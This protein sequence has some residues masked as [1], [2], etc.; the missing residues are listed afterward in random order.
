MKLIIQIPCFNEAEQLPQTLA[1]LPREVEGFDV[2]EW[3]VIDDGST[4]DTVA[5]ARAH[6]VDHLVRL[7]NN[8]GLATGFQAGID[9][10]LKLGADV[11]VN[12]DADNQYYGPDVARLVRPILEARAD[13]VIGDREVTDIK[14]FSRSKKLLQRLGSWV[15]RQ[16]SSTSV[17]DTTSGFRAYNREAAIQML[18]VSKFTYTLET[19]IQA[20]KL[21]VAVDH[22]SVRTNAKTRESRLFP[23]TGAYV[24]RNAVSIFRVYAQYEPLT[25]FWSLAAV[26]GVVSIGV[27]IRFVVAYVDGNG[28]GHVQSLILGAVL[29]IA[30]VVLWALGVIGD[31]L[32]AQRVMVQR[33]FE[34]VRRIELELEVPP[35]HYEPGG[36]E[37]RPGAPR[38]ALAAGA[39]GAE[40]AGPDGV[41][42]SAPGG[43]EAEKPGGET[44]EHAAVRAVSG[45]TVS[46]DGIVTGN[47]YDK[48]GSN[49]PVVRRLVG[50]FERMLD[51]L[52]TQ[53]RPGSLL[54]VGC[55]EGVHVHRWA[56]RLEHARVVGIDLE[57]ESIQAGW[58]ERPAP[59]LEYRIM[60]AENL[61]FADREFELV[62]AIEVLEHVPDPEHT[63][64]EMARCAER[65]LLVSVPR[66]PMWRMLNMARGAYLAELGNTP[67][68]LNHWSKRSFVKLLSRHG[69]LAEVRS[70]FPWTMLLVRT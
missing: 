32:A 45:V 38:R 23:S 39:G 35:S 44:E 68:H 53:A 4:D 9:T 46:E 6:G 48:Y 8:K 25:V 1:D 31:L 62:S 19:I 59:N 2:V 13:M 41:G 3:L 60:R 10:A 34:R 20:G 33:T 58:A 57:E 52:L 50:G 40:T 65:H 42:G 63:L 47:T 7:T 17:P 56:E 27:W 61:P 26:I 22:V 30:A 36:A 5:I 29:F 18:V 70:P 37:G 54:D 24:R 12:T 14:H 55:G 51:E 66:E 28:K 64:A 49:N 16:A 67:G 15:V 11:I 69:D 43:G 21:L